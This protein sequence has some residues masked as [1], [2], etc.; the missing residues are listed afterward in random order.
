VDEAWS[1][2]ETMSDSLTASSQNERLAAVYVISRKPLKEFATT[3]VDAELALD[4]WYRI[5]KAAEWKS[6]VD[7]RHAFPHAD[8]VDP[9]T[10]F[11]VKGNAYRLIVQI[12]YPRQQIFIK[13]V[14]THAEYDK[15][16]WK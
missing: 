3:H 15:D 6:I 4:V 2:V 9:Y 7:V 14:L 11:N 16:N 13:T 8:F 5:A 12:E 1:T 10:I